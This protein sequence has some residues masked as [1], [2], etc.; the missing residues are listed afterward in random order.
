MIIAFLDI[1][2]F[3]Q[4][5]EHNYQTA[6][7]NLN[8]FNNYISIAR[9][10]STN[11]SI[12]S[13]K[14]PELRKFAEKNYVTSFDNILTMSDSLVIAT[15]DPNVFVKQLST[16]L[17][18]LFMAT[19][20]NFS[21]PFDD[22]YDVDSSKNV[23]A[24]IVEENGERQ[25]RFEYHKVF[26]LLF[27]GGVT[28]EK[29]HTLSDGTPVNGLSFFK[30]S[31]V[32]DGENVMGY[33]VCGQDYVEAVKLESSGKG[34]RLFC[35]KDF[36]NQVGEEQKKYLRNLNPNT[37]EILWTY[38][39]CTCGSESSNIQLNITNGINN[40]LKPSIQLYKYYL[41]YENE[42]LNENASAMELLKHY[43]Q[44]VF[45]VCRG[46]YKYAVE[47]GIQSDNV[48]RQL[49]EQVADLHISLYL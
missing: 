19:S 44:L 40:F 27:R 24:Y 6:I 47:H 36:Y 25:C 12:D 15:N 39:C 30:Q 20:Q 49:N 31:Q 14:D 8:E 33:N 29:E 43:K 37:Y 26:P 2:G 41:K 22:I 9:G 17:C 4:L 38:E 48:K 21:K 1:L 34:P 23:H 13:Y 45:L 10:D 3:T 35:S 7:D 11:H 32:I 5:V 28:V 46:I 42:D 18:H 16:M